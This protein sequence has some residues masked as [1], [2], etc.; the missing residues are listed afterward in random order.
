VPP[1][2]GH[3]VVS[4][5]YIV[6][7]SHHHVKVFNL[8]VSDSHVFS[9][10]SKD[11]GA[12]ELK[13][14]SME[15]R[16]AAKE[17][18][19]GFFLWLGTKD[20]HLFELDIRS[21]VV[22]GTKL[23]AHSHTVTHIF[24]HGRSMISLDDTGKTLIF[25]P[26]PASREDV[27]LGYT[28]PRVYRI[29][30]KHDFAK[31][32]RGRL[33]TSARSDV[34]GGGNVPKTPIIRV[35]DVYAPGSTGRTMLP[36]EHVGAITSGAVLPSHPNHVYLGHEGGFISIWA[37]EGKDGFPY[38]IEAMKVSVSDVLSLDGVNDRLW[39]GGRKGMITAYDVHPRPWIVTNCWMAHNELPVLK[40]AVDYYGIKKLGRL[41]VLSA[42]R[43]E[44]VRFWDGLL[45]S[46]WIGGSSGH[47]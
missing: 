30:E 34:N 31:V 11:V 37:L 27:R 20:G 42:G 22:V 23:S 33:W 28:Q 4:G 13:V 47:C 14:T 16:P 6:V 40:L 15:F 39:A 26:D 12:K 18:E 1:Y 3:V 8:S 45:G 46:D 44:Q 43:D 9:L 41:R 17:N 36:T 21:G 25:T 24:R 35:Y 19:R 2:T 38:C 29:A 7:A 5:E 10:D 32:F